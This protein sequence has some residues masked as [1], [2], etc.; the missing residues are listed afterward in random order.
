MALRNIRKYGDDILRK[1]CREVE[2]VDERLLTLI[3]DMKETMYEADGVV[4]ATPPLN[5]PPY[6]PLPTAGK[7]LAY[8][9]DL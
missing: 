3:E 7:V 8:D 6:E 4:A 1:K 5:E 9:P 2:K